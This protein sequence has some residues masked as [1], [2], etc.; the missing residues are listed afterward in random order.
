MRLNWQFCL[1]SRSQKS[2][3]FPILFY[4]KTDNIYNLNHSIICVSN[5]HTFF[6]LLLPPFTGVLRVNVFMDTAIH[7]AFIITFSGSQNA[8]LFQCLWVS[9]WYINDALANSIAS[10]ILLYS[11]LYHAGGGPGKHFFACR[12]R[13]RHNGL[14]LIFHTDSFSRYML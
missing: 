4:P 14:W 1:K 10:S 2:R 12:N 13:R 6:T 5:G 7:S 8:S 9:L 3:N 11:Y